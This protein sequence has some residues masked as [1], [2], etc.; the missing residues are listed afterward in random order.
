MLEAKFGDD[1]LAVVHRCSA[2][3]MLYKF[4]QILQKSLCNEVPVLI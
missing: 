4:F 3:L 2:D 1:L